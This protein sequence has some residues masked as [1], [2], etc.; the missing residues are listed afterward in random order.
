M[1]KSAGL[2]NRMKK[3]ADKIGGVSRI[4]NSTDPTSALSM[5]RRKIASRATP[6]QQNTAGPVGKGY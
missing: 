4:D 6:A 5:A 1:A 3:F 2:M